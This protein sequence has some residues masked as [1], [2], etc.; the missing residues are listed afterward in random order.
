MS[1]YEGD[2]EGWLWSHPAARAILMV[3]PLD[4]GLTTATAMQK[5]PREPESLMDAT[6]LGLLPGLTLALLLAVTAMGALVF[7][8]WWLLAVPLVMLVASAGAVVTVV[9]SLAGD[10]DGS[11]RLRRR[12]PGLGPR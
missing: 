5:P 9:W 10:D 4:S 12:I 3:I 1:T 6:G 11:L 7:S 2:L 8:E